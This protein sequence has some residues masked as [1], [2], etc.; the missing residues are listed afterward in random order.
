MKSPPIEW[1][2]DK[3]LMMLGINIQ[4]ARNGIQE[5]MLMEPEGTGHLNNEDA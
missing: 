5:D 1:K 4:T 2:T 3:I